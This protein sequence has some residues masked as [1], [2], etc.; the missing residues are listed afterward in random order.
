MR[1][2]INLGVSAH[3]PI[4]QRYDVQNL[5][6]AYGRI[7]AARGAMFDPMEARSLRGLGAGELSTT[8]LIVG[9]A[10]GA[11]ILGGSAFLL[12]QAFKGGRRGSLRGTPP[13]YWMR[14]ARKRDWAPGVTTEQ[15]ARYLM[16]A[17]EERRLMRAAYPKRS[18]RRSKYS[19]EAP[20]E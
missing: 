14:E 11:L 6:A 15:G 5:D 8:T 1:N 2:E 9:T 3:S 10:L 17:D 18:K 7:L 12:F 13:A 4:V 19:G 16:E 20:E